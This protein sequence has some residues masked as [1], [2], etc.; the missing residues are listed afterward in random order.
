MSQVHEPKVELGT[1]KE[2]SSK[3]D[4][5]VEQRTETNF[6]T[7]LD[8]KLEDL[9]GLMLDVNQRL[10]DLSYEQRNKV[11]QLQWSALEE[12][13]SKPKM[14]LKPLKFWQSS[15]FARTYF[16]D[17]E[18]D[19]RFNNIIKYNLGLIK[20]LNS[21]QSKIYKN[22]LLLLNRLQNCNFGI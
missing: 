2:A 20:N 12:Y 22:I 6:P 3:I 5:Y 4:H 8:K 18:L 19:D 17:K 7:L 14:H 21:L 10:E 16:V 11:T 1:E 15:L 9:K 13:K